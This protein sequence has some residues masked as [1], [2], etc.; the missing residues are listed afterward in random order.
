METTGKSSNSA[1]SSG[2]TIQCYSSVAL[3]ELQIALPPYRVESLFPAIG[4]AFIYGKWGTGKTVLAVEIA[5][6][7]APGTHVF[8]FPAK[9]GRIVYLML[10]MPLAVFAERFK[11][12]MPFPD[13]IEWVFFDRQINILN[14]KPNEAKKLSEIQRTFNPDVVIVDTLRKSYA[15]DEKEGQTPSAVYTAFRVFFP[16]SLNIYLAHDRKF[17]SGSVA[18]RDENFSGHQAWANDATVAYHLKK[19]GSPAGRRSF[20]LTKSHFTDVEAFPP[21]T[22]E[23]SSDGTSMK[24]LGYERQQ[25]V[26]KLITQNPG[27]N[28]T[29]LDELI[30]EQLGVG[31]RQARRIRA[32]LQVGHDPKNGRPT[33]N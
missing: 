23:L 1:A 18:P 30:A 26:E 22:L 32:R 33:L 15:G 21:L 16:N 11:S 8:G 13:G 27:L 4:D 14:P 25:E 9:S 3:A 5:A 17:D 10:D 29:A 12:R 6:G 28:A 20:T 19:K 31:E 2:A 24:S 7:I